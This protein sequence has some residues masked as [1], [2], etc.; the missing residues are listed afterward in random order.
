MS[1]YCIVDGDMID[2][3]CKVYYGCEDMV[4]VVYEVNSGF[5][6]IGLILF[7]GILIELFVKFEI[8]VCKLVRFWG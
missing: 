6:V 4:V 3:I 8:I 5:V 1:F 2:V 7:K